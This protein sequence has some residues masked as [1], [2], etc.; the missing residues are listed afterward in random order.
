MRRMIE[1]LIEA[2]SILNL[3]FILIVYAD[4]LLWDLLCCMMFKT[5]PFCIVFYVGT[6]IGILVFY[7]WCKEVSKIYIKKHRK[8]EV[9][10]YL[11]V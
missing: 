7:M 1:S 8:I 2:S 4:I 3:A 10:E 11:A 9:K 5:T 6:M